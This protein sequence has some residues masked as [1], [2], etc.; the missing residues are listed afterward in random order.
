MIFYYRTIGSGLERL[1]WLG[2]DEAGRQPSAPAI[3][4][5]TPWLH[6]AQTICRPR[7]SPAR[8]TRRTGVDANLAP[9]T[10]ATPSRFTPLPL[11]EYRQ[12]P[13]IVT[14]A[15]CRL[16]HEPGQHQDDRTY[17]RYTM[18]IYDRTILYIID[19]SWTTEFMV[20][21]KQE[22]GENLTLKANFLLN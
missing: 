7:H 13:A 3:A 6:S 9:C 2:L 11:P 14:M 5:H 1:A 4:F 12:T 15:H 16:S 17:D 19:Q 8:S 21:L 22:S 20:R 10:H 18:M